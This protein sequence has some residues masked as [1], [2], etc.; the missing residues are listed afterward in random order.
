MLE[1]VEEYYP[2]LYIEIRDENIDVIHSVRWVQK[3]GNGDDIDQK[4]IHEIHNHFSSLVS[5]L[6]KIEIYI[7][8]GDGFG[9]PNHVIHVSENDICT[10]IEV[11]L[12]GEFYEDK[13]YY[14]LVAGVPYTWQFITPLGDYIT[15][16][17]K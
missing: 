10:T 7:N 8:H 12:I 13:E 17:L 2:D 9:Y 15:E 6:S 4:C 5:E 1:Y 16:V 3:Y 11:I 14:V